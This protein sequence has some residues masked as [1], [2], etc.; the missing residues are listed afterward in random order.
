MPRL[1]GSRTGHRARPAAAARQRLSS[2]D[3]DGPADRDDALRG[4]G[5]GQL[6]DCR[7]QARPQSS[8]GVGCSFQQVLMTADASS[9]TSSSITVPGRRSASATACRPSA[10]NG[11]SLAL[12]TPQ[13][14]TSRSQ[15]ALRRCG[16]SD[17]LVSRQLELIPVAH[18]MRADDAVFGQCDLRRP[19]RRGRER[20][21]W[22]P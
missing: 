9:A 22:P 6:G 3:V 14:P 16:K 12:L 1:P 21:P 10:R 18:A 13:Q 15:H 7:E 17:R 2:V 11:C 4:D 5:V 8:A 19:W 20:L